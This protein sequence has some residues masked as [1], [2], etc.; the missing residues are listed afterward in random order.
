MND[1]PQS[2]KDFCTRI[3][4][5]SKK[6]IAAILERAEYTAQARVSQILKDAE[7]Q[8]Q[9]ILEKGAEEAKTVRRLVLS[10]LNLEL[11]KVGLRIK[12]EII[13]EALGVLRQ[14]LLQWTSSQEYKGFLEKLALEGIEALGQN[15]VVIKLAEIDKDLFTQEML[16]DIRKSAKTILK[17]EISITIDNLTL[18]NNR[19]LIVSTIDGRLLYDNTIESRIER[20]S[21]DLRLIISRKIFG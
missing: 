13:E 1:Q 11:K 12:G 14:R 16:E 3:E 6:E 4:E 8:K 9:A 2:I 20:M 18:K 21:D 15:K 10:D 17:E 5:D 19:G 7:E